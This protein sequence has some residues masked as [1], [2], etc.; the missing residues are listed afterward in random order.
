MEEG[1]RDDQLVLSGPEPYG[2]PGRDGYRPHTRLGKRKPSDLSVAR[3]ALIKKGLVFAP[4]RGVLQFTVPH[5]DRYIRR[6]T[7]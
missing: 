1:P 2:R 3:D 4:D 6:R 5:M 7:E